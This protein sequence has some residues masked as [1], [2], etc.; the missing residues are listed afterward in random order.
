MFSKYALTLI[1]SS[2][3]VT[4]ANADH[5]KPS[6]GVFLLS[7]Q[8]D[9]QVGVW[10]SNDDGSLV[11]KGRYDTGGVGYPDPLDEENLDDLGSSNAVHYHVWNNTQ[12]LLAANAGG[13]DNDPSITLFEI[14]PS[15]ELDIKDV[16]DLK[17]IFPCT[18]AGYDDR[19]CVA[20][21]AAD[22]TMECFRIS[23]DDGLSVSLTPDYDYNFNMNLPIPEGRPN[24]VYASMGP[25]N[26]RF[27]PDGNGIGVL[28]KGS[29]ILPFLN[30]TDNESIQA[31]Q[32]GL[33]VFPFEDDSYQEPIFQ[34]LAN[35]VIPFAFTWRRGE[36]VDMPVAFA[37]NIAGESM[38]YPLCDPTVEC[39]SSV[40]SI[41]VNLSDEKSTSIVQ[42]I[43]LNVIDGCWIDY[44]NDYL[45]T[46]N[47]FSDSITVLETDNRGSLTVKRTV[48]IGENAIPNDVVTMGPKLD[49]SVYLYSE[50]QG[51]MSIGVHKVI[52]QEYVQVL[53]DVPVPSGRTPD[54]WHGNNGLA[55][56]VLSEEDLILLYEHDEETSNTPA[57]SSSSLLKISSMISMSSCMLWFVLA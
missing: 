45:Y 17:G 53:P 41:Q 26:I 12:W 13:P 31:A 57:T 20:T 43:P 34:T 6:Q 50:N 35:E 30:I 16:V 44:R 42:D 9:N 33:Y 38:D 24:R 19:V 14:Q 51:T 7:N 3:L 1:S 46:G 15:L 25:A 2:L 55:V 11:F 8:A 21:C 22:V 40:T 4:S 29:A 39:R 28:I 32:A 48:P 54:A 5:E 37:I 23:S 36:T 10:K 47:F 56:T 27:T 52:N 18:V 49:G